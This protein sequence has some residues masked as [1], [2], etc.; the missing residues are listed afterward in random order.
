MLENIM[1]SLERQITIKDLKNLTD[2]YA[3]TTLAGLFTQQQVQSYKTHAYDNLNQMAQLLSTQ[4]DAG[5]MID[6]EARLSQQRLDTLY[7]SVK[8]AYKD[9]VKKAQ[10][11]DVTGARVDML[12]EIMLFISKVFA[13]KNGS[14]STYYTTYATN[15]NNTNTYATTNTETTTVEKFYANDTLDNVVVPPGTVGGL[16]DKCIIGQAEADGLSV[17]NT[18]KSAIATYVASKMSKESSTSSQGTDTGTMVNTNS[19]SH[20]NDTIDA[21]DDINKTNVVIICIII[22]VV[23]LIMIGI[24]IAQFIKT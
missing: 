3:A 23:V 6:Q 2:Q 22:G 13:F 11:V 21:D 17:K 12:V 1:R 4:T 9:L 16:I 14:R 19:T 24:C 20:D 15:T 18:T 8:A 5:T 7:I 10:E